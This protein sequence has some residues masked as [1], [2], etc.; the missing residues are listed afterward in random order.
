MISFPE[1][2]FFN[3]ATG[4]FDLEKKLNE[5]ELREAIKV[6]EDKTQVAFSEQALGQLMHQSMNGLAQKELLEQLLVHLSLKQ[7][8]DLHDPNWRWI[9]KTPSHALYMDKILAMFPKAKFIAIIRN[10]L[11]AI[12]SYYKKLVDYRK[13]YHDLAEEYRQTYA[14]IRWLFIICDTRT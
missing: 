6:F 14:A 13:P 9:E 3:K 10:P 11:N 4:H 5:T 8:E 12:D 2:H 7:G 1:T